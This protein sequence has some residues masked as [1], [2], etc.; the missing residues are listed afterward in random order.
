MLRKFAVLLAGGAALASALTTGQPSRILQD[1]AP[2][3][4]QAA[5]AQ[6]SFSTQD[7][8]GLH[9]QFF[10]TF[11]NPQDATEA[12]KIN[13]TL[14]A[15]NV[16]GKIDV[17]R[18]FNGREL[19]TEYLFGLFANLAT[20][21]NEISLLGVPISY[22][23]LNFVGNQ[24]VVSSQVRYVLPIPRRFSDLTLHPLLSPMTTNSPTDP[25]LF[26]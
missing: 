14:L 3:K 8:Y 11:M 17:T 10:D 26:V 16:Q 9:K 6:P 4:R 1:V 7:L 24:N 18:T 13:S 12:K 5:V 22:E 19:N 20:N 21:A 2:A 25:S 23:I 15:E